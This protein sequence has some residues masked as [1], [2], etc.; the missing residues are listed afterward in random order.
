MRGMGW[1]YGAGG[2][3]AALVLGAL[4]WPGTAAAQFSLPSTFDPPAR[5]FAPSSGVTLPSAGPTM[6]P[7]SMMLAPA[8]PGAGALRTPMPGPASAATPVSLS[9]VARFGHDSQPI[10]NGLVWRVFPTH[11]DVG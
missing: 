8:G 10:T 3:L 1:R 2:M 9:L 6:V 5:Q 11:P 7:P 4:G